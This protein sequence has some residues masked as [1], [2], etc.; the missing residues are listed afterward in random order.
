MKI[1]SERYYEGT[2]GR[3]A[4]ARAQDDAL[5]KLASGEGEPVDLA[6]PLRQPPDLLNVYPLPDTRL[7]HSVR[8]LVQI[9]NSAAWALVESKRVTADQAALVG[10]QTLNFFVRHS[11]REVG[12]DFQLKVMSQL[13][14]DVVP[15]Q[16][17]VI[18][19]LS[20]LFGN[21]ANLTPVYFGLMLVL[22]WGIQKVANEMIGVALKERQAEC[23]RLE[24]E[25]LLT[26][27]PYWSIW[28]V[29]SLIA[30][31]D[32][33]RL[34]EIH[35]ENSFNRIKW[36]HDKDLKEKKPESVLL[37]ALKND[38]L[39]A[40]R[41]EE[42]LKAIY[43]AGKDH[44]DRDVRF[45]R[46]SAVLL[47]ETREVCLTETTPVPNE[48]PTLGEDQYVWPIPP[49]E[50]S[51]KAASV[52]LAWIA[53]T[54]ND[55]WKN[56]G[57]PMRLGSGE[58]R[59]FKKLTDEINDSI[60]PKIKNQI[61]VDVRQKTHCRTSERSVRRALGLENSPRLGLTQHRDT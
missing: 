17:S 23:R 5:K 35:D 36:Y 38:K 42:E 12:E 41:D 47:A 31:R 61:D 53:M 16:L 48:T 1:D 52:H 27:E 14:H 37:S 57:I 30:F 21:F 18:D 15:E 25:R 34:C 51:K 20:P 9:S 43:W 8:N 49:D 55:D 28:N 11:V 22:N 33:T 54:S 13:A 46:T 56:H 24:C 59:S 4:S 50:P 45:A 7:V 6:R 26:E 39:K 40:I 2:E 10:Y 44:V 29:L 60:L 3:S 19:E 32:V 58:R